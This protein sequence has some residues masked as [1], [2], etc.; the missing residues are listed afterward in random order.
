MLARRFVMVVTPYAKCSI[1]VIMNSG[2]H[3][4]YCINRKQNGHYRNYRLLSTVHNVPEEVLTNGDESQADNGSEEHEIDYDTIT[5]G[6][7]DMEHKLKIIML[8]TEVMRQEG[9]LVPDNNFFTTSMWKELMTLNSK[10]ARTRHL[11]YLFK[12]S[13]IKENRKAKKLEKKML[14]EQERAK[15]EGEERKNLPI[16]EHALRYGLCYNNLFLRFYDTTINNLYNYRLIQAMQFGQKLVIDC[17]YEQ[18]MTKLENHNCAKQAML[19]FAQNRIGKDPFD[20]HFCNMNREGEFGKMMKKYFP[21]IDEPSFPLN[22]H[23]KSYLDLYPKEDL[24][25]LTPHCQQEMVEYD[26]HAIYIIGGIVDK[27][28]HAPLSL[29]KAKKEGIKMYKFPLDRYLH[30]GAGS[31]KSLTLNHCVSIMMDIKNTG[32][33]EYALRH[34]PKRKLVDTYV[35]SP[36]KKFSR[37]NGNMWAPKYNNYQNRDFKSDRNKKLNL[38]L[39]NK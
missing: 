2:K 22:I 1:N 7:K 15:M 10:S 17:G 21:T 38:Y 5:G 29:A 30:W 6:N 4:M 9:H 25:Y 19:S 12:I 20:I 35:S 11:H 3:R 33:W 18:N 13:K 26:P 24:I 8:E 14:Y 16:E 37:K 28:N 36:N 23:E 34:V 31:G 39:N 32:N 27:S